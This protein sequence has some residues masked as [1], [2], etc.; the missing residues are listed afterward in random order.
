VIMKKIKNGVLWILCAINYATHL[1]ILSPAGRYNFKSEVI[2]KIYYV[3]K[4]IA[5]W[6]SATVSVLVSM[7]CIA[8]LIYKWIKNK[9]IGLSTVILLILFVLTII[10]AGCFYWLLISYHYATT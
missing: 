4:N 8:V 1:I 3:I 10:L 5:F 9:R 6:Y 2:N 7:A